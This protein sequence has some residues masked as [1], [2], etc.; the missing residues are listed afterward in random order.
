MQRPKCSRG[1]NTRG[2]R[3]AGNYLAESEV[4]LGTLE[5][6]NSDNFLGGMG[7]FRQNASVESV[8]K[9]KLVIKLL[10]G[11]PEVL[12]YDCTGI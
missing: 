8:S 7:I 11:I 3:K 1:Q 10:V 12:K 2:D 5:V 9:N 6:P 4:I